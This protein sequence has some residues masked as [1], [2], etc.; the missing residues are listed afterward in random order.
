M[1][2]KLLDATEELDL[3]EALPAVFLVRLPQHLAELAV[4]HR[5]LVHP[6]MDRAPQAV[7]DDLS[8]RF[9]RREAIDLALERFA[10]EDLD[11]L[12]DRLDFA[13]ADIGVK[14]LLDR[15]CVLPEVDRLSV[16]TG[17]RSAEPH[18]V[19]EVP[20]VPLDPLERGLGM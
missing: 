3:L 7:G 13:G 19:L 10:V 5:V 18:E 6:L 4:E 17:D 9:G 8:L 2:E 1:L 16:A 15:A 20:P 11:A 12:D 14:E